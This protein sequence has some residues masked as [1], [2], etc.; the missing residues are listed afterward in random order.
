[1]SK[2]RDRP[3][4]SNWCYEPP[5]KGPGWVLHLAACVLTIVAGVAVWGFLALVVAK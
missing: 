4:L 1:M 2:F 3:H 5:Q